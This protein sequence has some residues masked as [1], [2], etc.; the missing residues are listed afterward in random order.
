MKKYVACR[1]VDTAPT[2]HSD[3]D[4]PHCQAL[5]KTP[6]PAM[7]VG[8]GPEKE[9]VDPLP[10]FAV[11]QSFIDRAYGVHSTMPAATGKTLNV[12]V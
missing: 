5:R 9:A 4:R 2:P 8:S 11:V 6:P 3:M 7:Q 10:R 12:A 1:I